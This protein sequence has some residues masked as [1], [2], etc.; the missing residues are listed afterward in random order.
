MST[1]QPLIVAE[2]VSRNKSCQ[3]Q[4]V[5]GSWRTGVLP[6]VLDETKLLKWRIQARQQAGSAGFRGPLS[7]AP[8]GYLNA[9][10]NVSSVFTVHSNSTRVLDE[11]LHLY[12]T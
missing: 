8:Q 12:S 1:S 6:W 2:E 11:H 3:M 4:N 10:W 7:I 9:T 5:S